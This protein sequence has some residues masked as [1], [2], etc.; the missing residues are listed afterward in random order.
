MTT[1][2]TVRPQL[3][4]VAPSTACRDVSD[5][6]NLDPASNGESNSDPGTVAIVHPR[7]SDAAAWE[8]ALCGFSLVAD[9]ASCQVWVR[10]PR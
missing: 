7:L 4:E 9:T 1:S 6:R 3:T 10:H 2:Q 8:L 5:T